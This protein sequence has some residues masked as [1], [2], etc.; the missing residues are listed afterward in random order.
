MGSWRGFELEVQ[1]DPFTREMQ[2]VLVGAER[3]SVALGSDP[4]GNLTR[5]ENRLENIPEE[6]CKLEMQLSDTHR[7]ID[8]AREEVQR[9]FPQE[10]ELRAREARLAELNVLLNLDEKETVLLDE[11]EQEEREEKTL[12][13]AER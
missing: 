6:L 3:H 12:R 1:F 7:Q 9:P 4:G 5:M 10:E 2:A 11:T 13:V 8:N